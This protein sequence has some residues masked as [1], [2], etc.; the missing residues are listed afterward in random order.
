MLQNTCKIH[1]TLACGITADIKVGVKNSYSILKYNNKARKIIYDKLPEEEYNAVPYYLL[2]IK[3]K[4]DFID[5]KNGDGRNQALF[6]Y[7]L[8]LQNN[9]LSVEQCRQTITLINKYILS[10]PLDDRELNTILRDEAFDKPIFFNKNQFL[11]DKFAAYI[12]NNNSIV[13]IN[14]QLH[15]YRN[16][17]YENGYKIIESEMIKQIPQLNRYKRKEVLT[18]LDILIGGDSEASDAK[19]ICFKNCVYNIEDNEVLPFSPDLI[20]TNK[21]DFNYTPGAY[22]EVVDSV[23][24]KLACYDPDVRALL[25]EVIGYCFYRRNELR[26][27]IVFLGGASGGK[28]TYL[29]MIKTLLGDKNTAALDLK[30]L[31]DRFK[32]AELFG[33]LANIGDDIGDDFI[34]NPAV[35]KKLTSGDRLNAERK[36]QDPFDFN[37]YAKL[38]FSANNMP[39]IKDKSRAVIDRLIIVPFDAVFS[40]DDPDYD[41]DFDNAEEE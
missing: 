29:D 28:S 14:G 24:N 5:M 37:N 17:V 21:I 23:L 10:D 8:T 18:Y 1:C 12:R 4:C 31:G 15:I 39:R 3:G 22:S 2:P 40:K 33:K 36:G 13:K 25:E 11:F 19:Y 16:G 26:K 30:E 20:I 9:D 32:T 41:P 6:N 38:L 7:I 27:A 35:F 34:A